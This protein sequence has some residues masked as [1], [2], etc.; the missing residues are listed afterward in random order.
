V[1]PPRR[2]FLTWM[3]TGTAALWASGAMATAALLRFLAPSVSYEPP[4]NF[5]I[6]M[7]SD[8]PFGAPTLLAAE[9]VFIFRDREKGFSAASS[10]CTHL[11]CS[12][13]WYASD[14]SFHC[15]C[16]G[17]V[18]DEAGKRLKG[19]APRPLDWYQITLAPDGQLRVDRAK[20]VPPDRR[21]EV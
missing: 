11:G 16:H 17:T 3:R 21:L 1:R 18:F 8:F 4:Q 12:V 15:P 9:R 10:V 20:R 13:R 6:G 2:S 5:K 14:R 7:P 19:P